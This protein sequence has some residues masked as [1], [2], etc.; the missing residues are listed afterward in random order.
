ML[1]E[2]LDAEDVKHFFAYSPY[3]ASFAK[4]SVRT[5]KSKLYKHF[6]KIAAYNWLS[7]LDNVADSLNAT[8]HSTTRLA[9]DDISI[10]N[11]GSV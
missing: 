8:I 11:E 4:R 2:Y 10:K 5:V 1:K 6:T 3:H 7:V 9:P